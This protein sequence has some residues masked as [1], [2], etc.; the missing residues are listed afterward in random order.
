VAARRASLLP[1]GRAPLL[2]PTRA[3]SL[4]RR[5][6]RWYGANRRILPW[7][8]RS[9]PYRVWVAEVMLQQ[10]QVAA[11]LPYYERFVERFPDPVAL[12]AASEDEVLSL[13]A[14]LGYY[15]RARHLLRA[16]R[17][18]VREHGGRLPSERR[19]L[20]ALPG[21][22]RYTA[23]AILSIAFGKAEPV[24]DGNVRRVLSR[25]LARADQRAFGDAD[26][27][28]A[29]RRL[30]RGAPPADL[31][32]A[33]ME[34]GAL[35]CRPLSP[36]CADCPLARGC[37]ARRLGAQEE[38]PPPRRR[39][40]QQ[41]VERAVAVVRRDRRVL[42]ERG[43]RPG[44]PLGLWD[45]P[46]SLVP[47]GVPPRAAL[48]RFLARR[49]V[50]ARAGGVL[51]RIEHTITFRR[52]RT[53]AYEVRLRARAPAPPAGPRLRW[54]RPEEIASMP[55]GAAARRL[56]RSL[57]PAASGPGADQRFSG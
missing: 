41:K 9:D 19:D 50:R 11:V 17:R 18:I 1:A 42:L 48:E 31:N 14:G 7:R 40:A 16:A 4:R 32:Q 21:I 55:L 28:A 47:D 49:G 34:L 23:G 6:L 46:G 36:A 12:A 56:L 3:S 13:W 10:T 37:G 20:E 25:I 22:G 45:L 52:I 27:E 26:L 53:T 30:L 29:A 39:R 43:R 57:A 54:A 24:V 2:P 38:V 5:L 15:A 33:L 51:A 8:K 35:V 44:A